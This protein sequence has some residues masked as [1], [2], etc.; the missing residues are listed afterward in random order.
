ME[1]S[2]GIKDLGLTGLQE[3]FPHLDNGGLFSPSIRKMGPSLLVVGTSYILGVQFHFK[4]LEIELNEDVGAAQG[5]FLNPQPALTQ[6]NDDGNSSHSLAP[7]VTVWRNYGR[8]N[9]ESSM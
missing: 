2:C 8:I 5:G 6:R 3:A 7:K 4:G 9:D 1:K